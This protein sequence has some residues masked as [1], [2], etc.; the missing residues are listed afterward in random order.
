MSSGQ[1]VIDWVLSH[2]SEMCHL[3]REEADA[4][5]AEIE[6]LRVALKKI[7]EIAYQAPGCP[8]DQEAV[9][10][11]NICTEALGDEEDRSVCEAP[12]GT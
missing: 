3:D 9:Q 12:D 1:S 6:R 7:R 4:L 5:I 8:P 11:M 2:P 10:I